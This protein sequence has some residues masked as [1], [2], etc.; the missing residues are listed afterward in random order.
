MFKPAH[1][2]SIALTALMAPLLSQY[3][4]RGGR[5]KVERWLYGLAFLIVWFDPAYWLWEWTTYGKFHYA[6][7]LPL[8][9]CSLFWMLFPV[10]VFSR[11][12]F[13]KQMALAHVATVGLISGIM[14]FVFNYH[15]NAWPFVSFVAIRSLLYH[16]L[17]IF[18]ALLLWMSGYYQPKVFDHWRAMIPVVILLIP[19]LVLHALYG[20]DYGYTAG[21][22]GTA[23]TILSS[24]V[25]KPLFLLTIYVGL[26]LLI[27]VLFYR[28]LPL[29]FCKKRK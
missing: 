3:V 12:G 13:F 6:S 27:W 26:F 25:S 20:Y 29:L 9:L 11:P 1:L 14:G 10:G 4:A 21:G 2:M 7:T 24:V 19:S 23:F 8:Y 16:F 28:H 18:G 5:E 17:M 15:L 22:Q